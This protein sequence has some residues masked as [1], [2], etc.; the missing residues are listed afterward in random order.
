[1]WNI[2]LLMIIG[3]VVGRIFFYGKRFIINLNYKLMDISLYVLIFSLGISIAQ[4]KSI[5]ENLYYVGFNSLI[6]AIF[7]IIGS[8]FFSYFVYKKFF[9][10]KF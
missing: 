3:I 10:N 7:G 1:M 4:N 6:L 8:V 9:K 5:L 2:L